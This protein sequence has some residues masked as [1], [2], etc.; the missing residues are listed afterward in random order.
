MDSGTVIAVSIG[1]RRGAGK[2]P[3]EKAFFKKNHGPV[4]DA[5]AGPGPRQVALLDQERVREVR[6]K[7]IKASPGRT[8]K[9]SNDYNPQIPITHLLF[10]PGNR[11]LSI[12][13][14]PG[15]TGRE[16]SVKFGGPEKLLNLQ[17]FIGL[18]SHDFL[19]RPETN[20]RDPVFS[21]QAGPVGAET[22]GSNPG[23]H[24]FYFLQSFY[25]GQNQGMIF[26]QDPGGKEFFSPQ[27]NPFPGRLTVTGNGYSQIRLAGDCPYLFN[28]SGPSFPRTKSPIKP[29]PAKIGD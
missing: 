4:G 6:R 8:R 19:S 2:K 21:G 16:P 11:Q 26:R 18:M 5:H 3:T 20:R 10:M 28:Q 9:Y 12:R 24:A 7:G 23:G 29:D 14:F 17:P 22:P 15:K 13:R 1:T 27:F 25:R